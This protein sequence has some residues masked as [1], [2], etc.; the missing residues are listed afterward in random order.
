[1]NINDLPAVEIRGIR[2]DEYDLPEGR[3]RLVQTI[4]HLDGAEQVA[5]DLTLSAAE[6]AEMARAFAEINAHEARW[7]NAN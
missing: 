3:V 7:R 1:M 4:V 2:L 6:Y 5:S